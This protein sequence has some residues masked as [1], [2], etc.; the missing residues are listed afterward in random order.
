MTVADR[1]RPGEAT[2]ITSQTHKV[3][4]QELYSLIRS[5]ILRM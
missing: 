1:S 3:P 4:S 5:K 2:Q